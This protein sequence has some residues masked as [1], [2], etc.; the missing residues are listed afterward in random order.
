MSDASK[1]QNAHGAEQIQ[2]LE[3]LSLSAASGMYIGSTAEGLHHPVYEVV[4]AVMR[5][6]GRYAPIPRSP[7]RAFRPRYRYRPQHLTD[8]HPHRQ[9]R[10]GD[11]AHQLTAM[12][13]PLLEGSGGSRCRSSST[14]GEWLRNGAAGLVPA[15]VLK[16]ARSAASPLRISPH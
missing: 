7:R 4:T 3:G 13:A 2:V 5:Q 8:V 12:P 16:A 10:A 9:K 1:V 15:S 14:P 6:Q 11:G